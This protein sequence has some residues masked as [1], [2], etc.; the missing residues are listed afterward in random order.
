VHKEV[1]KHQSGTRLHDVS[2]VGITQVR[3]HIHQLLGYMSASRAT[4]I[5][6]GSEGAFKCRRARYLDRCLYAPS[7]HCPPSSKAQTTTCAQM[8]NVSSYIGGAYAAV[9]CSQSLN[10][11]SLGRRIENDGLISLARDSFGRNLQLD[12]KKKPTFTHHATTSL[13]PCLSCHCAA[14]IISALLHT[15]RLE[16]VDCSTPPPPSSWYAIS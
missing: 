2:D 1:L 9:S 13:N 8:T 7:P 14:Q 4:L 11:A 16:R 10:R 12:P 15:R 3:S 5:V 6:D